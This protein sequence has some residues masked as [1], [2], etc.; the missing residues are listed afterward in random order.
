MNNGVRISAFIF[1]RYIPRVWITESYSDSIF[2]FLRNL[3]NVSHNGC[4]SLHSNQTPCGSLFTALV[5]NSCSACHRLISARVALYV[6]C[7][8][9]CSS[10]KVSPLSSYCAILS[11]LFIFVV[12]IVIGN[13]CAEG[14][15]QAKL[16]FSGLSE[17]APLT[18]QAWRLLIFC[19]YAS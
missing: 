17:P 14:Q 9:I 6:V 11:S 3:H 16:K 7:S 5:V 12:S 10:G 8:L 1:F 18:I 2:T 19:V 13:L 15:A 4:I